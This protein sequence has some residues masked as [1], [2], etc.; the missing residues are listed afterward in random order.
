MRKPAF[1]IITLIAMIVVLFGIQPAVYAETKDIRIADSRGDWGYPNPYRHYPRGPGY[2][3]MSWIF[4]TL[5]W[6]DQGGYIPALAREWSYT[7]KDMAFRFLLQHN[8]KWHDGHPVN[9]DDVVFTIDYFK[10]HPYRWITVDH[11]ER[12]EAKG[13]HEVVIYL[14]KPY[15]PF[16]SD[17]GGTMP[18]LPRHIWS[19]VQDPKKFE[20]P[21]AFIGSG[22]YVFKDFNKAKGTYLFE[23]FEEYYQGR[24]KV[25]RLIYVRSGKALV[26]LAT[27]QVDLA[28]IQ[29][30]MA[31]PLKKKGME[32]IENER[33]WN[34]KLMINHKKFPFDQKVFRLALA[35]AIDRQ[36]IIDKAH[37][38]FA[39][40]A[41][42]GLLT[43][44]HD[45]Y[46]PDTPD[47]PHDPAKAGELIESLGYQKG[48]DGIYQKNGQPLKIELLS[49]N[50]TVAGESVADRDGEVIKKQLEKIGMK[51]DLINLEQ[52]TTDSRVKNWDFDLAVSGHGGIAGDP[53]I[54]SEMISSKYGAGSV[55]SAK[56]DGNDELN[57]LLEDQMVE[58]DPARRKKIVFRIQEVYAEEMPAI[59]LYY[60]D[61]M[62][63][64]NPGKNI[65]WF[66][67]KGGISKGIPIPQNKMSLTR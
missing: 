9:A 19:G 27:G 30:E 42:Y 59:S 40:P 11:I 14:A 56:F 28:N 20:A 2:V 67:T 41:S 35:H 32:V 29:P 64:Y 15:A 31:A 58:M 43:V 7:A 12:A 18:I 6:K 54:L 4:D 5:I 22:P 8:A 34:K 50:L 52:A 61:S 49:S 62:A 57:R 55:N 25:D 51:V 24:P 13:E 3:R 36:E 17:I 45:M 10:K 23:A 21:E 44:D 48:P 53:R 47:Y 63:A 65:K 38:G 16:I 1:G 60:P 46:N 37:R 39:A 66:Y 26:S 33:G